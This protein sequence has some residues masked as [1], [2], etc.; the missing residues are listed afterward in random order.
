MTAAYASSSNNTE[1][2]ISTLIFRVGMIS[3]CVVQRS[4]LDWI[5][6][7]PFRFRFFLFSFFFLLCFQCFLLLLLLLLCATERSDLSF[8]ESHLLVPQ[9]YLL[10]NSV[11]FSCF[12]S[13]CRL[14]TAYSH[15][16]IE[17]IETRSFIRV[18]FTL[19]F[20][21]LLCHHESS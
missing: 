16:C 6:C 15:E 1:V 8:S 13:C 14:I 4:I 11:C 7:L 5:V 17:R 12:L 19:S 21:S 9:R 2:V 10:N 18:S 20:S 3:S